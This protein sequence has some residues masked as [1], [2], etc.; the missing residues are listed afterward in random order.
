MNQST[1][2]TV[3]VLDDNAVDREMMITA[4]EDAGFHAFVLESM[5]SVDEALIQVRTHAQALVSGHH[6]EC[7]G[8]A[9]FTGAEIVSRCNQVE[10]I[11]AVLVAGH[12]EAEERTV[13]RFCR[14][15]PELVARSELD[16]ER[17][18]SAI[19][20][21][22]KE[23]HDSPTRE[24]RPHRALVKITRVH[25]DTSEVDVVVPQWD[26]HTE[27][28]VAIEN[29]GDAV[30]LD[31]PTGL[32]DAWFLGF[33]NTGAASSRDLYFENLEPAPDVPDDW[34]AA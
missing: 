19:H 30:E 17:L 12:R 3:A 15:I 9:S 13:R 21:A 4:V 5:D 14:G 10:R 1:I 6:L 8:G 26:P 27:V 22:R 32:H 2:E 23:L 34:M 29:L 20:N 11:P 24:R 25:P 18:A 7:A 33:V 28:R 31:D 16:A